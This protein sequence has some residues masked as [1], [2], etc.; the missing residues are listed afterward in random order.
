MKTY[1]TKEE[2]DALFTRV[3]NG[4]AI[5]D[6]WT[7]EDVIEE[8]EQGREGDQ[9]NIR[10]DEAAEILSSVAERHD[11][12]HGVTWYQIRR[13]IDAYDVVGYGNAPQ[14]E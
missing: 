3:C 9:P 1:W 13:E 12:N 14:D 5:V 4:Q 7:I 2:W 8:Y 11:A 10:E 6:V